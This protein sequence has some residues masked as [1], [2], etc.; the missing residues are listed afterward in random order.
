MS[1]SELRARLHRRDDVPDEDIDDII[2]LAQQRQDEVRRASEGRASVE[3][4]KAVAAELDIAPE[5]VEAAIGQLRAQREA[6]AARQAEQAR[7]A[8]AQRARSRALLRKLAVGAGAV[9]MALSVLTG[10][11]AVSGRSSMLQAEREVAEAEARVDAAVSRQASLA[12]QLAALAGA[13]GQDL[14][15]L[16]AAVR[17]AP[18]LQAR[19]AAADALTSAMATQL[20]Q[21]PPAATPA[22]ATARLNLQDELT[23]S[24][25]RVTI[26]LRRYNEAEAQWEA[27]GD[28]LS[29]SLAVGLGLVQ[30]P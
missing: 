24:Q 8:Q 21:L 5:H 10:G 28:T 16:Q 30:A 19:L 25:N 13:P 26:E 15:A 2:E 7:Q 9:L 1:T 17:D 14:A 22:E 18:D 20:G 23:G 3:Q 29:G 12:P 4:V 11:L 27:A 6:D